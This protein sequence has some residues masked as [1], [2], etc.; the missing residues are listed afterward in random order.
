[1]DEDSSLAMVS[2]SSITDTSRPF[3]A[4]NSAVSAPTSPPPITATDN[5]Y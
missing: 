2:R 3:S 1:M 4:K 5:P